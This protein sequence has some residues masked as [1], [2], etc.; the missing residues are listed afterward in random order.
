MYDIQSFQALYAY[1]LTALVLCGN[2]LILWI[3]SGVVRSKTKTASNPED[4]DA[5]R[6]KLAEFDP[7][8]VRRVLRAHATAIANVVPFLILA[9]V[10][11]LIGGTANIAKIIFG[12][13]TVGRLCH[14][15]ADLAEKQPW[16]SIF[17]GISSLAFGALFVVTIIKLTQG[18]FQ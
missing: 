14:A 10:Y 16:R 2:L 3:Y 11:V 1:A 12:M 5:F 4:A 18:S 13:F 8:E 15:I 6:A 17:S 9:L 7:P